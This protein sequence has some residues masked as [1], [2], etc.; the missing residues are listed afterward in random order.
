MNERL[1]DYKLLRPF[2]TAGGGQCRWTF[3]QKEEEEFFI[4]EF[5]RP[6]YPAAGHGS[7]TTKS[8]KIADCERF[9][10]HHQGIMDALRGIASAESNLVIA[11]DFF[12]DGHKYYKVTRKVD[13]AHG[14]GLRQIYELETSELITLATA[15][16]HSLTILHRVSIVHGDV[17][18]ANILVKRTT[19][20]VLTTKLIDFDDS[21]LSGSPPA[22]EELVGDLL[23]YSPEAFEYV[24][25]GEGGEYL[26]T[27]SDM[28]SLGL[29]LCEYFLGKRP[30]IH[31]IDSESVDSCG[32]ALL[33]GGRL[34][35]PKPPDDRRS[36]IPILES[37]LSL[38][39]KARAT[40][41]DV[42]VSLKSIRSKLT[43]GTTPPPIAEHAEDVPSS[44]KIRGSLLRSSSE[45]PRTAAVTD[46]SKGIVIRGKLLRSP[47]TDDRK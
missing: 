26:S 24:S 36:V 18:P 42:V 6:T 35:V 13:L 46:A 43:R 4:K 16:V 5:L 15:L 20:G 22:P 25:S 14:V 8:R 21:Y 44:V 29:V 27:A 9:E 10:R 33:E 3:G 23:Y 30:A 45:P 31:G 1:S 12:R 37:L 40:A 32:I 41:Q 7:E 19:R 28:F 17:K 34:A 47:L 38:D 11:T 39:P 2:S